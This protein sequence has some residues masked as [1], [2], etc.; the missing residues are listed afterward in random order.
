MALPDALYYHYSIRTKAPGDPYSTWLV[1]CLP[2]RNARQQQAA[3][4]EHEFEVLS[5]CDYPCDRCGYDP[6]PMPRVARKVKYKAIKVI[7]TSMMYGEVDEKGN[8]INP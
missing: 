3:A 8:V 7:S 5:I 2:C 4:R 6:L 1:Y